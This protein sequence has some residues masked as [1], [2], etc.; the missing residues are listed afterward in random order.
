MDVMRSMSRSGREIEEKRLVWRRRFLVG[1]KA[2]DSIPGFLV[3]KIF[4]MRKF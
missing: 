3:F 1:N 2:E 4:I